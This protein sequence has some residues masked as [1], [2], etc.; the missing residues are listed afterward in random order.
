MGILAPAALTVTCFG[1]L[2]CAHPTS[3]EQRVS[4]LEGVIPQAGLSAGD[5]K[6]YRDALKLVREDL[7]AGRKVLALYHLRDASA[8]LD[9]YRYLQAKTALVKG[10]RSAFDV[11]WTQVGQ[12]VLPGDREVEASWSTMPQASRAMAQY[13][14]LQSESYYRSGRLYGYEAGIGDGLFYV[15]LSRGMLDYA[16]L[17]KGLSGAAA[18]G[19]PVLGLEYD[20]D[21]LDR[22]I[23]AALKRIAPER[24]ND[25]IPVNAAFKLAKDLNRRGWNDGALLAYM[26]SL[27]ALSE[28]APVSETSEA[29]TAKLAICQRQLAVTKDHSL[30]DLF[31]QIAH[32]DLGS[33]SKRLPKATLMVDRI[34]PILLRTSPPPR[35]AARPAKVR[36]T[37]VRW[38][39]T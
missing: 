16:N 24:R 30:G 8:E 1:A 17:C 15:G 21:R 26:E 12:T 35:V 7:A 4:E 3:L 19:K 34:L 20:L 6:G 10:G 32:R 18:P 14:A 22:E 38:P 29:I 33:G 13:A 37:L 28:V 39:F 11:E 2:A 36:V 27:A 5:A 23:V 9:A 31:L 25:L